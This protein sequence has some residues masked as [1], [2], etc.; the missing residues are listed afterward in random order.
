YVTFDRVHNGVLDT[1]VTQGVLGVV[2]LGVVIGV[3]AHGAWKH[4][5][6]D[7]VGPLAAAC[8]AYSVWVFFNF[9]WAPATGAFWLL[10][11]TCW[12]AA[13]ATPTPVCTSSSATRSCSRATPPQRGRTT[14]WRWPSTRSG[15]PPYNAYQAP[16]PLAG[17]SAWRSRA[18]WGRQT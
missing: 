11:G 16:S 6:S 10:L 14:R 4:R 5:Q 8:V 3:V 13:S 17:R 12:S 18:G 2:A 7:S 15:S 1:A 9:D